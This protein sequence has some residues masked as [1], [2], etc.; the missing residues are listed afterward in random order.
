VLGLPLGETVSS[1]GTRSE[2]EVLFLHLCQQ[3]GLPRPDVNAT[4]AGLTVDFL[5]RARRLVVETDGYRYHRGALAFEND[6]QRDLRL[7]QRGLAVLR[8]SYGQVTNQPKAVAALI[9]R[10]LDGSPQRP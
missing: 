4:V 9:R 6:H 7:R 8:F 2:L 1:D 3:H 10:E 5:W